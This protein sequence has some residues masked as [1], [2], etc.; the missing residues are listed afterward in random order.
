MYNFFQQGYPMGKGTLYWKNGEKYVGQFREFS[1]NG[2]GVR[3]SS[4]GQIIQHGF[5]VNDV[6]DGKALAA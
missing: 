2:Y 1:L 5:Y 3:Y 4:A 6:W